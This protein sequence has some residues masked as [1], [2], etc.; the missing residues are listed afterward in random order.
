MAVTTFENFYNLVRNNV[1]YFQYQKNNVVLNI[2]GTLDRNYIPG[3]DED[4]KR[5]NDSIVYSDFYLNKWSGSDSDRMD[6]STKMDMKIA[7]YSVPEWLKIYSIN[8]EK[9]INI[10][11]GK[12]LSLQV[13]DS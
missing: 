3:S 12:I 8:Y 10:E 6:I 4:L 2:K 1:L 9:W 13:V 7:I 11:I 5:Y